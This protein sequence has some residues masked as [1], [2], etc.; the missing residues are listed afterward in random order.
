MGKV[1][2]RNLREWGGVGGLRMEVEEEDRE[3]RCGGEEK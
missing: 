3:G 2:K 1:G